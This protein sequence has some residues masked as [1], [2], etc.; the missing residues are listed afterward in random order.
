MIIKLTGN[1]ITKVFQDAGI[2]NFNTVKRILS[3]YS[4][5]VFGGEFVV[6]PSITIYTNHGYKSTWRND[7]GC[8]KSYEK[9]VDGRACSEGFLSGEIAKEDYIQMSEAIIKMPD[10]V[11]QSIL[12]GLDM[13]EEGFVINTGKTSTNFFGRKNSAYLDKI[14]L[15]SLKLMSRDAAKHFKDISDVLKFVKKYLHVFK[16]AVSE[17]NYQWSWEYASDVFKSFYHENMTKR[18]QASYEVCVKELEELLNSINE[19]E[20]T[21]QE[22]V[23]GETP[24]EEA[25]LRLKEFG[26]APFIINNFKNGNVQISDIGGIIYD[27]DDF[28]REL[29]EYLKEDGHTPYLV[30]RNGIMYSVLYVSNDRESWPYQRYNP[31]TELV[32]ACCTMSD[33]GVYGMDYGDIKVQRT[34]A[35]GLTRIQ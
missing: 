2:P 17:Y 27:L 7:K 33:M 26:V 14:T 12:Y 3:Q 30:L 15:S 34:S 9:S 21:E 16:Y 19:V 13:Y 23:F 10:G 6:A 20:A 4:P 35:G 5:E 18:K 11:E 8:S 25:I 22:H 24:K 31:R 1:N 32:M 28:G 29:V